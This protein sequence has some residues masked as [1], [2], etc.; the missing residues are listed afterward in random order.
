MTSPSV[1]NLA[2]RRQLLRAKRKA[3][4]YKMAWRS[5]FTTAIAVGTIRLATSPIWL[6]R[7]SQ[8]IEVSNNQLIPAENVRT[9]L[10][11]TYP[12]SLVS[13]QPRELAK[14]VATNPAIETA[15][16]R[17]KL[18]PPRLQV[19]LTEKIPVAVA[20]PTAQANARNNSKTNAQTSQLHS[21]QPIPFR[22]SGLIDAQGYWMPRNSFAEVG[23]DIV[24]PLQVIGM[25]DEDT[26]SWQKIYREVSRSPIEVTAIDW[27][28]SNNIV[29]HSELGKVQ[30]G[31]YSPQF[32]AQISALDQLR[33]I[34]EQTPLEQIALINL[35]NPK[36]PII[37]TIESQTKAENS[38]SSP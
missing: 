2:E 10:P 31:P 38:G 1:E 23:A 16:V 34:G 5:L 11:I 3:K 25:R 24:L 22:D 32:S 27:S 18:I 37:E 35:Q 26:L 17:R 33:N 6:I 21:E 30:I 20:L 28:D 15:V 13:L 4:F 12:K 36:N 9:L 8:Q 19:E 29:L 7:S 14:S